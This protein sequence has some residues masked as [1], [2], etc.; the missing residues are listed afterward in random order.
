METYP[1]MFEGTDRQ[2]SGDQRMNKLKKSLFFVLLLAIPGWANSFP[3]RA[4][5]L[6]KARDWKGL[7]TLANDR[8]TS[9]PKDAE[10]QFYLG[11]AL[12]QQQNNEAACRALRQC[13]ALE[14][15]HPKALYTLAVLLATRND[16]R[17]LVDCYDRLRFIAPQAA[18]S[19]LNLPQVG[20]VLVPNSE[21][22]E[23]GSLLGFS[24]KNLNAR[25]LDNPKGIP[26]NG[27][28]TIESVIDG[29]GRPV[30][31]TTLSGSREIT[32]FLLFE[33]VQ[34]K[35]EPPRKSGI[36]VFIRHRRE[37]DIESEISVTTEVIGTVIRR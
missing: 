23:D 14:K 4:A 6:L 12:S 26:G 5:E 28:A 1:W 10:A 19:L 35:Y 13:L 27:K 36:P 33:L 8:I 15:D 25:R 31:F 17:G 30:R 2:A 16:R 37:H 7:E 3:N 34:M 21:P 18:L 22:I 9:K 24:P 29:E 20:T 32:G 11:V